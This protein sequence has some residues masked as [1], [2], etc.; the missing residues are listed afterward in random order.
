MKILLNENIKKNQKNVYAYV[1]EHCA[2][3]GT[4]TQFGHFCSIGVWGGEGSEGS[5]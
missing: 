2:T 1:S 5:A 4:K 3:F